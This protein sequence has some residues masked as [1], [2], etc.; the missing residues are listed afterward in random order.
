MYRYDTIDQQL[1]DERVAQYRDKI[2][3]N[4]AGTL[5]DDELRPRRLQNG[6]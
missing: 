3:R 5:S 1:I 6:L 2:A 4:R